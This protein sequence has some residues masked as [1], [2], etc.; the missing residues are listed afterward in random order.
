MAARRSEKLS[1]H[2]FI[3][4]CMYGWHNHACMHAACNQPSPVLHTADEGVRTLDPSIYK[5]P[6]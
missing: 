6:S 1:L 2:A 4:A 3:W 5:D